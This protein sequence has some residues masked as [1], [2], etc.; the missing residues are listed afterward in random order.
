MGLVRPGPG[1]EPSRDAGPPEDER[2]GGH[3]HGHGEP[4]EQEGGAV[5]LHQGVQD[6]VGEVVACVE[7]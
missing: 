6:V 3:Q 1:E 7:H 2:G 4:G 5:G